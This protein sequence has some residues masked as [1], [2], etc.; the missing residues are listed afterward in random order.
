METDAGRT[1]LRPRDLH[2]KMTP[3]IREWNQIEIIIL[4]LF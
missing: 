2:G 1:E 3:G 4:R